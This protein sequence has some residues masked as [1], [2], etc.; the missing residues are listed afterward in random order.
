MA[1]SQRNPGSSASGHSRQGQGNSRQDGQSKPQSQ[2]IIDS[3]YNF[4]PLSD[5]VV[6]PEWAN[7]VSHDVPLED[8]LSGELVFT[9]NTHAPLLVGGNQSIATAD[10]PGEVAAFQT[11]DKQYAIPGSSIRGM[12]RSVLEIATFSKMAIVDDKRYGLR[13]ISCK[14]VAESYASRVRDRVQTGFLRLSQTG[15][16]EIVPCSMVRLNHRDLESWWGLAKPVFGRGAKIKEKYNKWEDLCDKRGIF[17]PLAVQI[18]INGESVE[19]IGSGSTIGYPVF[20]TQISDSKN[21]RQDRNGKW[22]H[23]KYKDFIFYA[24]NE[25]KAFALHEVD[26]AAWRDF[27]FIH[28]DEAAKPDMPWPNYWKARFWQRREVP[29]FYIRSE[30]KLQIGLAY[31]PKLAGDFSIYDMIRH[32]ANEHVDFARY[33]FANLLFGNISP[34]SKNSLKSRVWF[35]MA[36]A[37]GQ[38]TVSTQP[39]TILNSPKPTYFPNYIQQHASATDWKLAGNKPQYAT[40]LQTQEHSAPQIRG[41]K[42]YPV[43]LDSEIQVQTLNDDQ[44]TNRKVQVRLHTLDKGCKF[45]GS[46]HFHNLKPEE[47]GALLWAID[48]G[49]NPNCRHGLGMG[50]AFGF[51]Q[52]SVKLD[53]AQS[54]IIPNNTGAKVPPSMELCIVKFQEYMRKALGTDWS[55]TAQV[56]A[57]VAMADTTQRA[58]F[59]GKLQHMMLIPSLGNEFQKAKQQALTLA[60]YVSIPTGKRTTVATA[61]PASTAAVASNTAVVLAPMDSTTWERVTLTFQKNTGVITATQGVNR[62]FSDAKDKDKL[63]GSLPDDAAR[64]RLKNSKLKANLTLEHLGGNNWKI[65]KIELPAD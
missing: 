3:P 15:E 65:V 64:K 1:K 49:G 56:Q 48:F 28:G 18:H 30:I 29:V 33:D 41:W 12:V 45:S 13:D 37:I 19:A 43:H 17:N 11:P 40:Y 2:D 55:T 24:R 61:P 8:G 9:L 50:K 42:R 32:T 16:P 23:G 34:D 38:P 31:M 53:T 26:A 58:K 60:G 52:L 46:V 47:L 25:E 36:K 6:T 20:T 4:V 14:Y 57:L 62:A 5:Q 54:R 39:D 44:N 63:L 21:D 27:L 35:E 51:G 7:L 22:S 59:P 10:K